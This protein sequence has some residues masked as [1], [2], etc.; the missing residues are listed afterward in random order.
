LE[1][2]ENPVQES[3]ENINA[4][5]DVVLEIMKM[6]QIIT[7]SALSTNAGAGGVMLAL[8]SDFVVGHSSVILNPHY[9]TMQLYGSE[10]WTYNL[11]RKFKFLQD[12]AKQWEAA[13]KLT[14]ECK[15]ISAVQAWNIGLIDAIWGQDS[16][17]FKQQM[18]ALAQLSPDQIL[19][20]LTRSF[21]SEEAKQMSIGSR[22]WSE[23]ISLKQK[24][25][26]NDEWLQT[27]QECRKTELDLMRGNFIDPEYTR[28]RQYFVFKVPSPQTPQHLISYKAQT[29]I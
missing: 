28:K 18:Y 8:A 1:A 20:K 2:S 4:I 15:A 21:E 22:N 3:W 10:Y 25:R 12:P 13:R 19:A 17:D 5:N 14:E 26:G 29:I 27:V 7:I 23:F 6:K 9:K 24:Q 16:H 11:P